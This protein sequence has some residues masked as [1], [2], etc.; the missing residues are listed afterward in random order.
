[1]SISPEQDA[2]LRSL[3]RSIIGPSP[4]A[5][6]KRY[7]HPEDGVIKVVSGYWTDPIYGRV[8]NFWYWTVEATG[9][10]HHGYGGSW[11]EITEE[12]S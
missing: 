5:V 11:P 1:M 2:A 3:A 6:G 10:T 4:L 7:E 9:E 12:G 8:S